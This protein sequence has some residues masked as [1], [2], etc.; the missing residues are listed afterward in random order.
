M[1]IFSIK[2]YYMIKI[3]FHS[4]LLEMPKTN[5]DNNK[6][7]NITFYFD[8]IDVFNLYFNFF[9]DNETKEI[10]KLLLDFKIF[11]FPKYQLFDEK[12]N[13]I[14]FTA[15][16]EEGMKQYSNDMDNINDIINPNNVNFNYIKSPSFRGLDNVGA[17][18]YMNATLQCLANIKPLTEYFLQKKKYSLLFQNKD[19]CLLTLNYVQVLIGLF[20]NESRNGSYCPEKFKK[21]TW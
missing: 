17:T 13:K 1:I 18:C 9:K 12:N 20:C 2:D 8:Y 16:Y 5:V 11:A 6:L 15:F 21:N 10:I 3:I 7:S 4:S 14:A 19:L